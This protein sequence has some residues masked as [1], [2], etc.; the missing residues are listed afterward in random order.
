MHCKFA[1][2]EELEG[3]SSYSDGWM[4]WRARQ[5]VGVE[6]LLYKATAAAAA[7]PLAREQSAHTARLQTQSGYS[8]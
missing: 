1:W 6:D 4:E 3:R 8:K 5:Q 2:R 7:Q